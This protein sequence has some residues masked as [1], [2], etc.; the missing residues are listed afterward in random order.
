ML[1]KC[2]KY[3]ENMPFFAVLVPIYLSYTSI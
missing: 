1:Y 3:V 2:I